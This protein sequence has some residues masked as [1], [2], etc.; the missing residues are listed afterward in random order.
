MFLHE[1]NISKTILTHRMVCLFMQ[2][3]LI[4]YCAF[5]LALNIFSISV[6]HFNSCMLLLLVWIVVIIMP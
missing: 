2:Q 6:S 4:T 5:D 1:S 3:K